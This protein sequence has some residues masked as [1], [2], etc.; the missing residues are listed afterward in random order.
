M[1]QPGE[2]VAT[3]NREPARPPP[4]TV[5]SGLPRSGTSMMMR[6]LE[7]GGLPA[8]SDGV[9]RANDD[10]PNGYYE[11]EAVKELARDRSWL[12]RARGK[13]VKVLCSRIRD[14]PPEHEYLVLFMRRDVN[15]VNASQMAMLSRSGLGDVPGSVAELTAGLERVAARTLSWLAT[16]TAFGVI[17]VNYNDLLRDPASEARRVAAF[18]QAG[19]AVTHLD[20]D[21]MRAVVDPN[22][23]RQRA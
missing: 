2:R 1:S 22:L 4:I 23:Y 15:E 18:L 17:E 16:Q 8:L 9:R 14:L 21:A 12:S 11:L 10:N 13:A 19:G 6:M 20:V 3:A 5:V 7:A